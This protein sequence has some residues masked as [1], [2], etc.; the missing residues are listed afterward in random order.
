MLSNIFLIKG[1]NFDDLNHLDIYSYPFDLSGKE[2]SLF[3]KKIIEGH[4]KRSKQNIDNFRLDS[5]KYLLDTPI[6]QKIE[7]QNIF[8]MGIDNQIII[9][10]ILGKY[11]D[12]YTGYLLLF[13]TIMIS[14]IRAK[15][16]K[17]K[18][19]MRGVGFMERAERLII[20]LFSFIVEFWVYYLS[21][22]L[23]GFPINIFFPLFIYIYILLLLL[24][25][26]QRIIFSVK[27]LRKFD[28]Q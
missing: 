12:Y 28:A 3:I 6:S 9:G 1:K 8:S 25:I 5:I 10:L 26:V 16:E 11:V 23:L 7:D 18:I 19:E 21:K 2:E 24:T 27:S 13:L 4:E 20:L 22:L 14:Y 17:E 15:A